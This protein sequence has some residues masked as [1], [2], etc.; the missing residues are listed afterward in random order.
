MFL[1][2]AVFV[3]GLIVVQSCSGETDDNRP[4]TYGDQCND[5]STCAAPFECLGPPNSGPYYPF[6]TIRCSTGTECPQWHATGHCEGP[7]TPVCR[8]GFCDYVRCD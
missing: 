7:I 2:R 3:I 8:D 4:E 6:C 1:H 5:N